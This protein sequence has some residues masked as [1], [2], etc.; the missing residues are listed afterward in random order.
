MS[1]YTVDASVFGN[2]T[3]GDEAGHQASA[4]FLSEAEARRLPLALPSLLL[5]ELAGLIARRFDDP[6]L[7]TRSID[8]LIRLRNVKL[9]E[10]DSKRACEAARIASEHRLR[11]ADAVYVAVAREHGATLVTH[12]REQLER[13]T[14]W[15]EVASPEALLARW[16]SERE[17]EGEGEGEG[18]R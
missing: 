13:A 3:A 1:W 8:R 6:E 14:A 5:C 18:A 4:T 7:A 16:R 10:L 17:V 9:V 12:D 2:A 15:V 11:G